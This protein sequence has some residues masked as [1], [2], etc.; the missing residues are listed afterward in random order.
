V[1]FRD[2][3]GH[4]LLKHWG[5]T[6]ECSVSHQPKVSLGRVSEY[7]RPFKCVADQFT[8][9]RY[10]GFALPRHH[11][12]LPSCLRSSILGCSTLS[13]TYRSGSKTLPAKQADTL[14]VVA[15]CCVLPPQHVYHKRQCPL[16]RNW[17]LCSSCVMWCPLTAAMLWELR[18]Q[19]LS[20]VRS[21]CMQQKKKGAG[22][23]QRQVFLEARGTAAFDWVGTSAQPFEVYS[24]P[25]GY[26]G[27]HQELRLLPATSCPH[28]Q[29]KQ[30]KYME[31]R[32]KLLIN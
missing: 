1:Q 27:P 32:A 22:G 17:Q 11:L 2:S 24:L 10:F 9:T 12:Q 4:L 3:S 19:L 8:R 29:S 31:V 30:V 28:I 18:S 14:G 7:T 6:Q 23:H 26:D 15:D 21:L 20:G 13:R 25:Q 16:A 5:A